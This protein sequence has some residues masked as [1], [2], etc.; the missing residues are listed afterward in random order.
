MNELIASVIALAA[1]LTARKERTIPIATSMIA[2]LNMSP[3]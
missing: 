2:L 3:L 1:R